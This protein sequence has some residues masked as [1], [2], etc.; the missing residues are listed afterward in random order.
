MLTRHSAFNEVLSDR[1]DECS[2]IRPLVVKS[3][4]LGRFGK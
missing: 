2:P 1:H 3:V 4:L